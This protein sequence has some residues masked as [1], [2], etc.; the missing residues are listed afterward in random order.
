MPVFFLSTAILASLPPGKENYTWYIQA[1]DK[2]GV[3]LYLR[4]AYICTSEK[5][6]QDQSLQG[7]LQ[8]C[9]VWYIYLHLPYLTIKNNQM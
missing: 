9:H 8:A 3:L 6:L 1:K 4:G 5:A 2:N 7:V